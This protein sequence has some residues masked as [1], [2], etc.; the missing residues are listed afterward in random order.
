[1]L[2]RLFDSLP[3]PQFGFITYTMP[4][5]CVGSVITVIGTLDMKAFKMNIEPQVMNRFLLLQFSY[6]SSTCMKFRNVSESQYAFL[7]N[8]ILKFQIST[9]SG[10]RFAIQSKVDQDNFDQDNFADRPIKLLHLS[11]CKLKID[12][13]IYEELHVV[14]QI[15]SLCGQCI[16]PI[17]TPLIEVA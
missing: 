4:Y 7:T 6:A 1:M 2:H 3:R 5:L 8:L 16:H 12:T 13:T 14:Q 10:T 11:K 9:A 15:W 17:S